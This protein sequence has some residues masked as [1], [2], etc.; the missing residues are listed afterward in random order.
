MQ[1]TVRIWVSY[2]MLAFHQTMLTTLSNYVYGSFKSAPQIPTA[3]IASSI[4]GGVLKLPLGKTLN[5][6]GRAEGLA[7]SL[8]IY[9]IGMIILAACNG[10][11]VYVAGYVLYWIGYYCIYL[12]LEIF[13]ADTTGLRNRA[14]AFA[15]STTPFICTGFTAPLAVNSFIKTSGWRWGFGV[16]AITQPFVF[17]SLAVVF[18]Y[19]EKKAEKLGIYKKQPSGRTV[20][21][22]ILHYFH[23]F[24]GRS[25]NA[26]KCL[27][28]PCV[29]D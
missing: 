27:T 14:W 4:I 18:K 15:F 7:I 26:V 8:L 28:I 20:G 25:S 17:G 12:I 11:N 10:P 3:Y 29:G 22:S 5:L 19:Y 16:F 23:E 21:Q 24:D 1:A 9:T 6:W 13:I 2:F